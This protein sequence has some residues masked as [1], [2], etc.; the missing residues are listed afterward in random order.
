L[1]ITVGLAL[2]AIG[3]GA[4]AASA[5]TFSNTA[6]ITVP[7]TV[8]NATPY[9]SQITVSGQTAPISDLNVNLNGFTHGAPSDL[10]GLLGAPGGQA[11]L[12]MACVGS[13]GIPFGA[14]NVNVK[15]DDSSGIQLPA[16]PGIVPS[17]TFKPTG[18]CGGP[19]PSFP[20]P[21]PLTS[22]ANPGPAGGGTATLASA[23]NGANANGVWSLF[24]RDQYLGESGQFAGG[25]SLEISPDPA[26][27]KKCK[28]GRKLKKG[29]CVKKKRKKKKK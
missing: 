11:L 15:L 6:P 20:S 10:I 17:G 18:R 5:A 13:D 21:G 24:V 9:P 19:L 23:F 12:L 1:T 4:G 29:K 25:W 26:A 27:K 16:F 22:Y 14:T 7:S 28:K 2:A 3:V 8:S